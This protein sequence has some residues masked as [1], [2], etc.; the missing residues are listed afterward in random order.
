MTTGTTGSAARLAACPVYLILTATEADLERRLPGLRAAV[1]ALAETCGAAAVQLR[2]KQADTAGRLRLLSRLRGGLPPATLLVVNDDLAAACAA[3]EDAD[4]LHLGRED[5]ARLAPRGT[6][7]A[8]AIAAG[9]RAARAALPPGA[10][11]GT[12][13]RTR[14]EV[15]R[16]VEAGCDHVG[17][18]SMAP[19]G[20]KADATLADPAELRQA[21]QSW[22]A[23]PIFPIGG[24]GPASMQLVTRAGVR[25]AAIGAA[26]LDAPDPA[27]A[28]RAC[29]AALQA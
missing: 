1:Q 23:L 11:L 6:P 14:E 7:A 18:G 3:G 29:L 9:L 22:P 8:A 26:I 28:A 16:A 15:G 17:F 21:A 13:T 20:T 27:A 12:S 19:T 2:T 5:A 10:L 4:G 25:R 24:V